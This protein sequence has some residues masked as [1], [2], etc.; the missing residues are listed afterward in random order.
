MSDQIE[1]YL[2][3]SEVLRVQEKL[4]WELPDLR[5][6]GSDFLTVRIAPP[7]HGVLPSGKVGTTLTPVVQFVISSPN[8]RPLQRKA[9]TK[10][11]DLACV[12]QQHFEE[13]RK[14]EQHY[15]SGGQRPALERIF[16]MVAAQHVRNMHS[17]EQIISDAVP[18]PS[19]PRSIYDVMDL[20]R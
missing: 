12:Y 15:V 18:N 14:E 17:L 19:G 9:G 5:K 6:W 11:I 8:P 16:R 10:Q 13:A 20:P 1:P 7:W 4:Y 3:D 2:S